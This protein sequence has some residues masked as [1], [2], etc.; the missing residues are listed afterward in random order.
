M[1]YFISCPK[2]QT[3][4]LEITFTVESE[5]FEQEKYVNLQLP[6]WRPGRYELGNF[7]KNIQY[8]G[9]FDELGQA[10]SFQKT[11]KASW[12]VEVN[13]AKFVTI[14]YAY[15]AAV[16]DAG[17]CW[18]DDKQMYINPVHCCLF[19][20]GFENQPCTLTLQVDEKHKIATSLSRIYHGNSLKPMVYGNY[21]TF[22]AADFHELADSPV[23]ASV[24]MKHESFTAS[25]I[26]FHLW[27]H[28]ESKPDWYKTIE[29]F[30]AFCQAQLQTMGSFPAEEFH[31]IFQI[32]SYPF[33]HGV[34][35]QRS[36]VIVLGPSY[37][38]IKPKMYPE[39][40]GVS[41]HELFHA[42]NI[43][44]IRPAEMQPYDYSREN[45][46]KL[47]YVAE[48]IT[49]YY[50]DVFLFRSGIFSAY[51]MMKE[52][53]RHVQKHLDNYGRF[54]YSVAQSSWDTWLDGYSEGIPHRKVSIYTEGALCAFMLDIQIR[55]H[56][57][58]KKS[59]DDVMRL[60]YQR[61]GVSG[62]GYTEKDYQSICEE[63]CHADLQSFF[64]NYYNGTTDY[65]PAL[66]DALWYIGYHIVKVRSRLYFENR[67]GF[68]VKNDENG[69]VRVTA[70]APNSL[71]EQSGLVMGDVI[72]GINGIKLNHDLK[73][74]CKYF[75][76]ESIELDVYSHHRFRQVFLIP[77]DTDRYYQT[78]SLQPVQNPNDE[79]LDNFKA[80]SSLSKYSAE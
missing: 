10:L 16:L 78:I 75:Q 74:W 47:G 6:D 79:Q 3:R 40:L 77:N 27:M 2:P 21:P 71:A 67:F 15:Y 25:G 41:S 42:W 68:R 46:S 53:T 72:T 45:F 26:K 7:A 59:L 31:F 13:R 12:K 34:E 30:K 35:H 56:T 33:Y 70:V 8:W 51:E 43:K 18:V 14:K 50:G 24:T 69:N 57:A 32:V 36:T 80:W 19:V 66:K 61:F 11:A 29:D 54:N 5:Y 38:V 4:L 39:L 37:D 73:E 28:G 58:N 63:V 65:E 20:P 1:H 60:M 48:G 22:F 64:D 23:V 62:I 9:A 17:S 55:K 76:E 49:T 44:A 52:L